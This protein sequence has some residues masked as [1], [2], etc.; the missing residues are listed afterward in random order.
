MPFS[1]DTFA[2]IWAFVDQFDTEDAVSRSDLDTA[3]DD[4]ADGINDTSTYLQGLIDGVAA[5]NLYLGVKSTA[6]TL[7]NDGDALVSGN[8]YVDSS[9]D[10]AM[11]VWDGVEAEWV[12]TSDLPIASDYFKTLVTAASAEVLRGLLELGSAAEVDAT[13]F[14]TAAQGL[15]AAAAFP[16]SSVS[17]AGA[18]FL[19]K[20]SKADQRAWLNLGESALRGVVEE[21]DF[22]TNDATKLTPQ[23]NIKTFVENSIAAAAP[24]WI[25]VNGTT[26]AKIS[27]SDGLTCARNSTGK[28]TITF[29]AARDDAKYAVI[30]AAQAITSGSGGIAARVFATP[31]QPTVNDFVVNVVDINGTQTDVGRVH[32]EI[33]GSVAA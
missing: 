15:L 11:Y 5:A 27:G 1:V 8:F 6:P 20:T 22:A 7:N 28:Y 33:L 18:S 21:D 19:E 9:E 14:A 13:A 32:I 3:L 2:R 4:L 25:V 10:F 31:D 12:S 24:L 23:R 17:S 26:G 29:S 30:P 16:A